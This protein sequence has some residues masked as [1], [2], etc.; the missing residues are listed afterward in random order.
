MTDIICVMSDVI[1]EHT[2]IEA[3]SQIAASHRVPMMIYDGRVGTGRYSPL[4]SPETLKPRRAYWALSNFNELYR[5]GTQTALSG[6]PEG[7]HAIAA[8]DGRIG[9]VFAANIGQEEV[10]L[11]V[12]APSWRVLSFQRTDRDHVNTVLAASGNGI[13]LPADSFGVITFL[14]K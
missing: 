3:L 14:R 1:R 9:K 5:L 12:S 10:R 13:A 2:V 7:V 4:F 8:T 6:A 11:D